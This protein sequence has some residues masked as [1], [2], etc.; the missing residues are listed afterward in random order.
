MTVSSQIG[1]IAICVNALR[2]HR[3]NIYIFF[4]RCLSSSPSI[5]SRSFA[6]MAFFHIPLYL[7]ITSLPAHANYMLHVVGLSCVCVCVYVLINISQNV[8]GIVSN[9]T[10]MQTISVL[11]IAGIV[12]NSTFAISMSHVRLAQHMRHRYILFIYLFIDVYVKV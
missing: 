2:I 5:K 6:L 11:F 3:W 12:C 8:H 4:C 7:F 9:D 10:A 1:L